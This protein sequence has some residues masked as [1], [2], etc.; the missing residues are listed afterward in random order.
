MKLLRSSIAGLFCAC[1]PLGAWAGDPPPARPL[2]LAELT[3]IA[4]RNNPDTRVAWAAVEQSQAAERIARA[5]W[6]PTITASYTAQRSKTTSSSDNAVPPRTRYGP[7]VSL[8]YLLF[9]FG[10][11]RGAID[12]AA[13]GQLFA[14]YSLNQALQDLTL[15]VETNYYL[16]IGNEALVD[17]NQQAVDEAQA[18]LDAA[19]IKHGAGLATIADVYQAESAAA[20]AQLTLQQSRGSARIAR[21]ALAAAAGYSPET[22]LQLRDWKPEDADIVL[23]DTPLET[24]MEQARRARPDLLAAQASEQAAVAAVRAAR[25]NALPTLEL[26]ASAGQTHVSDVGMRSPYSYGATLS[27][28]VF[29]GFA[30]KAAIDG[31]RASLDGAR[32]SVDSMR[33]TVEQEVWSAYQNVQTA[34]GSLDSSRAQLESA[35]RAA[36]AIRARYKS[37]LSSILDLLTTESAL[38]QARVAR[39]Q[40]YLDWYLALT[41]LAHNAGGLQAADDA[42]AAGVSP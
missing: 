17:A 26:S 11:R 33:L 7:S 41:T 30:L 20:A 42:N 8:S 29:Q 35:Q 6:W 15:T 9:D 24:L 16:V 12:Q 21:G 22:V 13:A 36:D 4:L 25:G 1:L 5:G 18:N 19:R 40:A 14:R 38:A 3:A 27:V 39:I 37:G 28:P 23:P 34:H 2:S 31:A 32:A 10:A